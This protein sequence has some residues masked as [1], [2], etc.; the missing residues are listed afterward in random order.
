V[1]IRSRVA[2]VGWAV[3]GLLLARCWRSTEYSGWQA[4]IR[5][6]SR[7][8][9]LRIR[10]AAFSGGG[11]PPRPAQP[12]EVCRGLGRAFKCGELGSAAVWCRHSLRTRVLAAIVYQ[13]TPR[14]PVVLGGVI[15]A[16][17]V[18]GLSSPPGFRLFAARCRAE[19][20]EHLLREDRFSDTKAL[21]GL[22]GGPRHF[23]RGLNESFRRRET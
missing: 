8:K 5:S 11:G 9:E 2:T 7:L 22:S 3:S 14:E 23:T 21:A 4:L 17:L 20:A 12:R 6:A 18:L 15:V 1:H 19:S 13:A 10:L 16:W